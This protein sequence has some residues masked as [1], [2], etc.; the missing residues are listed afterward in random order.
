METSPF[1]SNSTNSVLFFFPEAKMKPM[2][3]RCSTL[4]KQFLT[5]GILSNFY[6]LK[7]R[8]KSR[9]CVHLTVKRAD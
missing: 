8:V 2:K 5:A 1:S 7:V 3:L 4:H 6:S 9:F